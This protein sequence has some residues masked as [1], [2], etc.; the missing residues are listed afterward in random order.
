MTNGGRLKIRDHE[1]L[2]KDVNTGAIINTDHAARLA[3]RKKK[4]IQQEKKEEMDAL[5]SD[6]QEIKETLNTLLKSLADLIT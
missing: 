6:V 1:H 4:Q 3:Y 5:K 2:Y